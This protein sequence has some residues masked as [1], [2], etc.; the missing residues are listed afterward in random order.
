[1][2]AEISTPIA[3][4]IELW[5]LTM[6]RRDG[7]DQR[8][9]LRKAASDLFQQL[10][11]DAT[12]HPET[13]AASCQAVTAALANMGQDIPADEAGRI[14]DDARQDG[15]NHNEG[16]E[17]NEEADDERSERPPKQANALVEIAKAAFCST[18]MRMLR[19]S[20]S[21]SKAIVRRGPCRSSGFRLW[22]AYRY[23]EDNE[24]APNAEAIRTA[25]GVMEFQALFDGPEHPVAVRVGGHDG[26]LYLDLCDKDW[27]AVEIDDSGWDSITPKA[28]LIASALGAL[29]FCLR[30]SDRPAT[31]RK[32]LDL[33]GHV[34]TIAL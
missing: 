34:V 12:V 14:L 4:A 15:A 30:S 26:R 16:D 25:L 18:T 11:I 5:R 22:L 7:D 31:S 27:R 19:S 24:S 10:K 32:P 8:T 29:L 28:V 9:V 2:H 13:H 33:T 20:T 6:K 21:P 3:D 17:D 1:M 23:Y